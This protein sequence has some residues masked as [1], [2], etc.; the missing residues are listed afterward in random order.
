VQAIFSKDTLK[1]LAIGGVTQGVMAGLDLPQDSLLQKAGYHLTRNAVRAAITAAVHGDDVG[2]SVAEMLRD[3]VASSLAEHFSQ[4]IGS[5]YRPAPDGE[6]AVLNPFTHKAAHAL[7]G[8]ITGGIQGG[9]TGALAGSLGAIVATTVADAFASVVHEKIEELRTEGYN[10]SE[11][12]ALLKQHLE[13]GVAMGRLTAGTV[14]LLSGQDVDAAISAAHTATEYNCLPAIPFLISAGMVVWAAYDVYDAYQQGGIEAAVEALVIQGVLAVTGVGAFKLAGKLY[15]TAKAAWKAV[16]KENKL[17]QSM[18]DKASTAGQKVAAK[19]KP[20]KVE[21]Q[22]PAV[23]EE[24][25]N[26]KS[27]ANAELNKVDLRRRMGKPHAENP[28]LKKILEELH[29]TE[30]NCVG[31][32]STA[33]AYREEVITGQPVGGKFHNQKVPEGIRRLEKWLNNNPTA[34]PGDRAAAENMLSDLKD[35]LNTMK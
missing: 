11:A 18:V 12:E 21:V 32:G 24:R 22:K 19:V 15:P 28:R 2:F 31:S 25:P 5:L 23:V 17:L 26:L 33:A 29:R 35:A 3:T 34:R 4:K 30:E 8:A 9:E 20:K 14:A 1:A 16:L 27:A 10:R 13:T 7:L 6:A